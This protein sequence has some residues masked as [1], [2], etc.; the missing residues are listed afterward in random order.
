VTP[1]KVLVGATEA[2]DAL[3]RLRGKGVR[4]GRVAIDWPELMRFKRSF[5]EPVPGA[6]EKSFSRAGIQVFHGRARFAGP[7]AVEVGNQVLEARYVD[8]V[9]GHRID[10]ESFG[11]A[12]AQDGLL[13][14]GQEGSSVLGES[15]GG[16]GN[17]AGGVIEQGD[18]V[19]LAFALV[20]DKDGGPV[21]HVTHP[22]LVGFVEG[23]APAVFGGGLGG[24]LVHEA[25]AGK[26]AVHGGRSEVERFG[27]LSDSLSLID[28]QGDGE[29]EVVLLDAAEKVS[30]LLRDG[31]GLAPIASRLRVERFESAAAIGGQPV[32]Q[33]V[34]RRPSAAGAR[35]LV[36][37]LCLL[38][39]EGIEPPLTLWPVH[40]VGDEPIAKQRDL[41]PSVLIHGWYSSLPAR[42]RA[43]ESIPQTARWVS[44]GFVL[45]PML[46]LGAS[47]SGW[48]ESERP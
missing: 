30:Y 1:K 15:E 46:R 34:E 31:P 42:R 13:E 24:S 35:D 28:D 48:T 27:Q 10:V 41:L 12:A 25:V 14:N 16:E 29:S 33:G 40:Q 38:T 8:S 36:G 45:E 22:E 43:R 32:P 18:Q 19:S 21:H 23:E 3:S 6:R 26:Q 9:S 11:N 20:L 7:T 5:N 44:P 39:Q 47:A 4:S 2:V 37:S 17:E